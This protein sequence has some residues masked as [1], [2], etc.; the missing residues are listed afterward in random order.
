L[1][2]AALGVRLN[3]FTLVPTIILVGISTAVGEL[4]RGNQLTSVALTVILVAAAIQGSYMA[5][6]ITR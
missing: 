3:V 6:S 1:I 2:G 4:A 5:V